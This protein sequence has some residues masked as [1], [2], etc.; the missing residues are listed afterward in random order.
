VSAFA[1]APKVQTKEIAKNAT[2]RLPNLNVI[3]S[4]PSSR[5]DH[6]SNY[7]KERL[8]HLRYQIHLSTTI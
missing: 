7:G 3:A 1:N 5:G 2:R 8:V 4:L 6:K